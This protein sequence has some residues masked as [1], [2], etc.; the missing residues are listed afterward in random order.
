MICARQ[1]FDLSG[2]LMSGGLHELEAVL[3]LPRRAR[4]LVVVAQAKA[5]S[6]P[7]SFQRFLSDGLRAVGIGTCLVDLLGRSEA[8]KAETAQELDSLSQ[9]LESVLSHLSQAADTWDLPLAVVGI[10]AVAPAALTMAAER[11]DLVCAAICCCGRP[12]AARIDFERLFVPTLLLAP[13]NNARLLRAHEG[14]FLRLRCSS[15]L[16]V[17]RGGER[18]LGEPGPLA[19]CERA[20][21]GWCRK[22]LPAQRNTDSRP[23]RGRDAPAAAA[24]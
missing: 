5:A 12:D 2:S 22:H 6:R 17:I 14:V 19:E 4:G 8:G 1:E 23:L 24:G 9:R 3:T 11:P 20:I 18:R 10:D 13:D 7:S 15:Q 21:R 16:A